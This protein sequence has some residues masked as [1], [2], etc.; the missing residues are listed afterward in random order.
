MS[1]HTDRY[2]YGVTANQIYILAIYITMNYLFLFYPYT[3]KCVSTVYNPELCEN[4]HRQITVG[5]KPTTFAI[6][7]QCLTK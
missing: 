1:E 6:L 5:F 3:R 7:E 4:N 2:T